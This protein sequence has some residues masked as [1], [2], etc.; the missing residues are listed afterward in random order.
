MT[1]F[2]QKGR[3]HRYFIF[4]LQSGLFFDGVI[5]D[6]LN[7]EMF[8]KNAYR[9]RT[10]PTDPTNDLAKDDPVYIEKLTCKCRGA[11]TFNLKMTQCI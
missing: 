11:V 4:N 3:S 10:M 9:P 5:H 6:D 8:G 7:V 1:C 2:D